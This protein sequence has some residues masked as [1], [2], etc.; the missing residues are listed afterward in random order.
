MKEIASIDTIFRYCWHVI[1]NHKRYFDYTTYGYNTKHLHATPT[2]KLQE[3]LSKL[4][5]Y[6]S[7]SLTRNLLMIIHKPIHITDK[8]VDKIKLDFILQKK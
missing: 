2:F 7:V 6:D 4:D 8:P 3:L 5:K 1:N